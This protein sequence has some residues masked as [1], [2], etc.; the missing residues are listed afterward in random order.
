MPLNPYYG[1]L[2]QV[3]PAQMNP[4]LAPSLYSGLG[5]GAPSFPAMPAPAAAPQQAPG[6]GSVMGQIGQ[7]AAQPGGL[8]GQ[9]AAP[10]AAPG[11]APHPAKDKLIPWLLNQANTTPG[12][13]W[14]TQTLP[15][16]SMQAW[17]HSIF[18]TA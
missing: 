15:A 11:T 17:L 14:N 3:T 2:P 9:P 8:F 18:G 16:G 1:I 6:M 4:H 13:A 7:M 10:G 12:D 5:M